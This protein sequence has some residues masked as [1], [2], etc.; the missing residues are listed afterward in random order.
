MDKNGNII[1]GV[2]CKY[3]HFSFGKGRTLKAELNMGSIQSTNA[4]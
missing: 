1:L 4:L 2:L 3:S